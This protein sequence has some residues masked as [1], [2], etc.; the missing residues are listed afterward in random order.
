[1]NGLESA[2]RRLAKWLHRRHEA[3]RLDALD[4]ADFLLGRR[5]PMVPPRR[6][7]FDGPRDPELYR[8]NGRE[9]LGHYRDLCGLGPRE[10]VLDV[11]SGIGRK[12]VPLTG[13]LAP[14]A[15]Y[16]G[17][18]VHRR[19]VEWCRSRITSRFPNFRFHHV[20]VYN[21][22]YNPGGRIDEASYR[23]PFPDRSFD[24]VVMASVFTHMMPAGVTRY[25][26]ET[27]R[28]L[29][30]ETGRCLI[31]FFL[32]HPEAEAGIAS[33]LSVY[34]FAHRYR[35]HAVED[36]DLP[37]DAVAYHESR[38][39]RLYAEAGLEISAVHHGSWYG[40]PASSSPAGESD[41]ISFQDLV[42]AR[43]AFSRRRGS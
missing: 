2:R 9:F 42:V 7:L 14:E 25:L 29:K 32:L 3:V 20:D 40:R 41:A 19:G 11:G 17:L 6:L 35:D 39:L 24:F 37:E 43:P 22:R 38:V 13:Y 18:D 16:E 15:A 28:V 23:F 1:M 26:R 31:S 8:R 27:A 30:P 5:D 34:R 21:R 10:S 12:T 4:V 33:S 36:P